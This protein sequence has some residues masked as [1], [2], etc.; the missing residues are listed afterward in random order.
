[1]Y[2]FITLVHEYKCE[3]MLTIIGCYRWKVSTDTYPQ[4][5]L[6]TQVT[7]RG[8]GQLHVTNSV[9]PVVTQRSYDTE[10]FHMYHGRRWMIG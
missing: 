8:T 4:L 1:M 10:W 7:V 5:S 6:E 9:Q 3:T 2:S